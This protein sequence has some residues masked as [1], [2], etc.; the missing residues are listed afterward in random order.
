MRFGRVPK[1]EKERIRQAMAKASNSS[2][3]LEVNDDYLISVI[4]KSHMET[5]SV[6]RDNVKDILSRADESP[7]V[8][9]IDP[10][11]VSDLYFLTLTTS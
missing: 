4:T 5:C 11:G 3:Q 9:A 7:R 6:A 10:M 2:P 1:N 8:A